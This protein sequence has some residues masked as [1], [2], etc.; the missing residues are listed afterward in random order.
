MRRLYVSDLDF[1]LLQSDKELSAYSRTAIN[2]FVKNDILFTIASARSYFTLKPLLKDVTI[3]LPIIEFNGGYVTNF[4]TGNP[5]VVFDLAKH[6]SH[7]IAAISKQL[8]FFPIISVYTP[9]SAQRAELFPEKTKNAGISW[10]YHEKISSGMSPAYYAN[11]EQDLDLDLE[12]QIISLTYIGSRQQIQSL[13]AAL[14]EP[15]KQQLFLH[16]YENSYSPGSFWLNLQS[17]TATKELAITAL[18]ELMHLQDTQLIVFGDS[19]ND[20]SMF[21]LA[22]VAVAVSNAAPEIKSLAHTIIGSNDENSVCKY[23]RE[24]ENLL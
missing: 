21:K 22:D 15:L 4:K 8:N 17:N 3:S 24:K 23:I 19:L 2:E 16:D 12:H 9:A 6:L 1:T 7:E 10:Y 11:L 20:A 5:I 14:S 13:L 18:R